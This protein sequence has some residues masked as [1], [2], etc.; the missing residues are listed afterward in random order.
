[1]ENHS[2]C[3][4]CGLAYPSGEEVKHETP[5]DCIR[6]LRV[7]MQRQ[8]LA[9]EQLGMDMSLHFLRVLEELALDPDAGYRYMTFNHQVGK[10]E[11]LHPQQVSGIFCTI[12]KRYREV[13]NFS[14]HEQEVRK[15]AHW[16]KV[17]GLLGARALELVEKYDVSD[18][19]ADD[20]RDIIQMAER[21]NP[22]VVPS[23]PLGS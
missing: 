14:Y 19:D 17:A 11:Q 9:A 7:A 12:L 10:P 4:T 5:E 3:E 20:I 21:G 22:E 18:E 23:G 2:L 15:T 1:M 13:A 16:A 6:A 8:R